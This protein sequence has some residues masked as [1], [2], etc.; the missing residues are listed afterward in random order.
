MVLA[1]DPADLALET[2]AST[3]DNRSSMLQDRDR[4]APTEIDALCGAVVREGRRVGVPTP[5]NERL[6]QEVL[7]L[8]PTR[9]PA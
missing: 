4:G 7:A 5:L 8:T 1:R 6:W 2:A 9:V 3:A